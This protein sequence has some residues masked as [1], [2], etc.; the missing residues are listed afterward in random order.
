MAEEKNVV[1]VLEI[2]VAGEGW[3]GLPAYSFCCLVWGK[4][5]PINTPVR[6]WH[7]SG[8]FQFLWGE[9]G[10]KRPQGLNEA[11]IKSNVGVNP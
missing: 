2:K 3:L 8:F 5:P 1:L 7:L 6:H 9:K 10:N 11:K 4:E